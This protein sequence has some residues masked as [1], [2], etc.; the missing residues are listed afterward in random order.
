[1]K[2]NTFIKNY[3]EAFTEDAELPILFWYTAEPVAMTDKINGCFF[4]G[5]EQVRQGKPI[6][7]NEENIGC[8]GGKL[9]TGYAPMAEHIPNFVS[10]QE[11]YKRTPEMVIDYIDGLD[12]PKAKGR[13]LNFARIDQVETFEGKEGLFFLATPDILSGLTTWAYFDNNNED[14]VT[15][16]FGSGCSSVVTRAV[17]ENRKKGRKTFVGFFDPSV[18]PWFEPNLLSFVI[19]MV[20]FR[21]M[22]ETMRESCLFDTRAWAKIK[23]RIR[24]REK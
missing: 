4:K 23:E 6:S 16:Y 9:Y 22:Y 17:V 20:R 5:M 11:R 1:M 18:R 12:I 10:Q 8:G 13:F 24:E 21:E 15:S 3:K 14:A 19:P 2:I 7:L